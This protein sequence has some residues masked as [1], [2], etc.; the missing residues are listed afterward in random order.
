MRRKTAAG[1]KQK[2]TARRRQAP[3]PEPAP[4]QILE[5]DPQGR[6]TEVAPEVVPVPMP[7]VTVTMGAGPVEIPGE[8]ITPTTTDDPYCHREILEANGDEWRC[9]CGASGPSGRSL[10]GIPFF[11]DDILLHRPGER[12][13]PIEPR[14]P[15]HED[16]RTT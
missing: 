15:R 1:R 14:V 9:A 12:K 3:Q 5:I 13:E 10:D 2:T 6:V 16:L 4:E 11:D 7:T 8:I